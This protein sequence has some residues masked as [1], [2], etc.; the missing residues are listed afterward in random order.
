MTL[1]AAA[2]PG[3][4]ETERGRASTHH[5]EV[6]PGEEQEGA[7]LPPAPLRRRGL[8]PAA[9]DGAGPDLRR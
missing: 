4:P 6:L 5:A 2:V 1:D 3:R 7:Q 9:G 8:R